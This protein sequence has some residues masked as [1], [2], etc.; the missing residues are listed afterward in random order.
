MEAKKNRGGRPATG[1]QFVPGYAITPQT[2]KVYRRLAEHSLGADA[3]ERALEYE[4][5]RIYRLSVAMGEKMLL[6]NFL[7]MVEH[8]CA[9]GMEEGEAQRLAI[10][11]EKESMKVMLEA[12]WRNPETGEAG[13]DILEETE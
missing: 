11:R 3:P 12:M 7:R 6:T 8:L 13:H 5:A 2:R 10:Q 1:Q 4:A 9:G